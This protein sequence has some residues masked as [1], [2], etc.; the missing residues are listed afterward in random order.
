MTRAIV[1]HGGVGKWLAWEIPVA[2]AGLV[3]AVRRGM[4]ALD[5]NLEASVACE[6]TIKALEDHTL[7]NAG[8][9]PNTSSDLQSELDACMMKGSTLA[10]GACAGVRGLRHPIELAKKNHGG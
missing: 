7:F 2:R 6:E 8:L 1:A 5:D 4:A 10:A 9:G 3:M